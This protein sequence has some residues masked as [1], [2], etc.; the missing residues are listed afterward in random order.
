MNR[1][2]WISSADKEIIHIELELPTSTNGAAA[3]GGAN[4][5]AAE[6]APPQAES[7]EEEVK[8]EPAVEKEP[9]VE[10]VELDNEQLSRLF[11]YLDE[12]GAGRIS[13]EVF[14]RLM[15][16][17]MKV[18]KETIMTLGMSIKDKQAIR[19]LDVNEVVEV[20]DGP[21]KET[22]Y[23]VLRIRAKALRD[24]ETG[25]I[26]MKGNQGSVFLVEGGN[27]FK[28]VKET[29]ITEA[30]ELNG[31]TADLKS[32]LKDDR[33]KL[34][35]GTVLEVQEWPKIEEKSGLTRMKGKVRS[36]GSI[37]WVTTISSSGETFLENM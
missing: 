7:V 4:D 1:N 30:F 14:L 24:G 2:G 32:L 23:D 27:L 29:I 36:S 5:D 33:R 9:T 34:K 20:L 16:M 12:E 6:E 37:G 26:T 10:K 8:K 19:R 21:L 3:E 35:E 18:V 28:V 15:R 11:S 22:S 25:W 17:Y 13:R 31:D